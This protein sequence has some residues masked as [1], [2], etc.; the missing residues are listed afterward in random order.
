MLRVTL[1]HSGYEIYEGRVILKTDMVG[2]AETRFGS[3]YG[4]IKPRSSQAVAIVF[5]MASQ[6]AAE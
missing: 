1:T 6:N 2:W 3:A 4:R 5:A